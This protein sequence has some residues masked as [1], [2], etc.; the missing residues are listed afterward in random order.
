MDQ[1]EQR[2]AYACQFMKELGVNSI[3]GLAKKYTSLAVR[4]NKAARQSLA[5]A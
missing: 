1:A 3:A 2:R 4:I 5:S